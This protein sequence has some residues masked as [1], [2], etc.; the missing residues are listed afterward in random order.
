[1]A[2]KNFSFSEIDSGKNFSSRISTKVDWAPD[3]NIIEADDMLIIE[4]ELPGVIKDDVTILIQ[5][6]NELIIKGEKSQP[7]LKAAQVT[8]FLFERE[9]GAFYKK[10]I[11]DFPVDSS[12]I[13]SMMENG[14]LIIQIP[15]KKLT[16]ISV[17]IK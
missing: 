9:F 13:E 7:R 17:D 8:Y 10:I 1:M 3:T 2:K 4:V 6:T 5:G 16:K 12:R 15:R 11:V 14:V